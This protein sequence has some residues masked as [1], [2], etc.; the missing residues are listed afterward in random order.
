ML[1]GSEEGA[2]FDS[3]AEVLSSLGIGADSCLG[4]SVPA[5]DFLGAGLSSAGMSRELMSSP[6]SAVTAILVP[7]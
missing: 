5:S 4:S 1:G 7:T 3:G 6:G 2:G